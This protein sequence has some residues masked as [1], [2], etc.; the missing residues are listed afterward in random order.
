MN[1]YNSATTTRGLEKQ[2]SSKYDSLLVSNRAQEKVL[3]VSTLSLDQNQELRQYISK[4]SQKIESSELSKT[5]SEG[6]DKEAFFSGGLDMFSRTKQFIAN[7]LGISEDV[8]H[9]ITSPLL[10]HADRIMSMHGGE[11]EQVIEG[12]VSAVGPELLRNQTSV[13]DMGVSSMK[14]VGTKAWME[15]IKNRLMSEVRMSSYD[16]DRAVRTIS[17]EA[18][19]LTTMLRP[20]DKYKIADAIIT[21]MVETNDPTIIYGLKDSDTTLNLL[22]NHL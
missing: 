6:M 12:L 1:R 5:A 10:N 19:D 2:S 21:L 13:G 18:Q 16:A 11:Q 3:E 15:S 20:N 4:E 8:A 14:P 7:R 22:R 9:D 17:K